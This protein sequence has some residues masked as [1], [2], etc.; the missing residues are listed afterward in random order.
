[1][2]MFNSLL[3]LAI[4]SV[5]STFTLDGA[6]TTVMPT[7]SMAIGKLNNYISQSDILTLIGFKNAELTLITHKGAPNTTHLRET[8]KR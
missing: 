3:S 6:S 5:I 7:L 1:M 4:T 8:R 2:E